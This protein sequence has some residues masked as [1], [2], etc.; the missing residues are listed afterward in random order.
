MESLA[1]QVVPLTLVGFRLSG[2]FVFAPL[3]ASVSI[4]PQ[5]KVLL[6]AALAVALY[7]MVKVPV[8]PENLDVFTFAVIAIGEVLIGTVIGLLAL[9]PVSAV[10]VAGV[11]MGQQIGLG[12]A[13]V[14]NPAL[15]TESDLIGEVL[16]QIAMVVFLAL[17]GL[18]VLFLC[19]AKSF[20]ALPL[21]SLSMNWSPLHLATPML[22]AGFELAMRVSAPVLGIV[23]VETI[24]SSMLMKTVPQINIQSVGVGMKILLGMAALILSLV[25]IDAAIGEH[26]MIAGRTLLSKSA[27]VLP[28]LPMISPFAGTLAQPTGGA[29]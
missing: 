23:L 7:P 20:D 28:N 16:L 24:A 4:P 1:A 22:A 19:V 10:Q 6:C 15:E 18:E 21:G 9:I 14:F 25:A 13:T 12:L 2:L 27:Q 8:M 11:L 26:L 29:I 17:G 5:V 3:L